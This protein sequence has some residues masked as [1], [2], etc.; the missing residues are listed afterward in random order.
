MGSNIKKSFYNITASPTEELTNLLAVQMLHTELAMFT[1]QLE[2]IFAMQR[3]YV[4]ENNQDC[5][6]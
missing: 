3:T 4:K 1:T 5:I 2:V 6:S